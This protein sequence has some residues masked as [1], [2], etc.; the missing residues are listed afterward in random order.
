MYI[1]MAWTFVS[2]AIWMLVIS[3]LLMAFA[4]MTKAAPRFGTMLAMTEIA[5][6]PY[7]VVTTLM[8]LLVLAVSADPTSLDYRNLL[9][10]NVGAFL[11][12]NDTSKALYALMTSI[13]I[14]S[15]A[16]I[17]LLSLGFSKVTKAKFGFSLAVVLAL[18]A[19]TVLIGIGRNVLFG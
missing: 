14:L 4:T 12:R 17:F 6:F 16:E 18:W 5:W 8:T 7:A 13:D 10:T 11:N 2:V 3:G 9:A 1:G 19:V 15:F